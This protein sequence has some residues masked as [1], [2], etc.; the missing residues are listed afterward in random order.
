MNVFLTFGKT[1]PDCCE[2]KPAGVQ[3][4][5]QNGGPIGWRRSDVGCVLEVRSRL[6]VMSE[7][8]QEEG[9]GGGTGACTIA[10]NTHLCYKFCSKV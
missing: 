1:P 8:L 5:S 3:S 7:E 10:L 4:R 2:N 6:G 9:L